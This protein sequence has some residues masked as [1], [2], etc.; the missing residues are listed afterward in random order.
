VAAYLRFRQEEI[1]AQRLTSAIRWTT[2]SST[3]LFAARFFMGLESML[4][5]LVI[6][7]V[8]AACFGCGQVA[9]NIARKGIR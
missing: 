8:E 6:H 4:P 1:T 7:F 9:G 3:P 5:L 2:H